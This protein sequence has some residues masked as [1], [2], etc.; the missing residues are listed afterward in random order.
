MCPT[1][2]LLGMPAVQVLGSLATPPDK[3]VA[4]YEQSVK[5]MTT[6]TREDADGDDSAATVLSV[7]FR[8]GGAHA[9]LDTAQHNLDN[10]TLLMSASVAR[11]V[12]A[13]I[14][15]VLRRG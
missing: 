4:G 3:D 13:W 5:A 15:V 1:I 7:L 8:A 12:R 10:S 2:P 11:R 14:L 6:V 9:V